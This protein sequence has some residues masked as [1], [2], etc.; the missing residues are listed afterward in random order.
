MASTNTVPEVTAEDLR[1]SLSRVDP[2]RKRTDVIMRVVVY[3]AFA[4]AMAPLISLVWSVLVRGVGRL[5]TYFLLNSMR[6]VFGGMDAGGAYHAIVG[7]LVITGWAAL[8]SVPIGLMVAIYLV[9][10]GTGRLAKAVTFLVDVMTGIPSIVAGLFAFALFYLLIGPQKA[11]IIGSVA[12]ALLMTP[13]VIRSSEEMLRLVPNELRE[14]SYALGVPKW[15]TTIKVVLR[16]AVAGLTTGVMLA[17]ARVIGETAPLIITVGMTNSIN[18]DVFRENM[19]TLPVYVWQQFGLG[20]V[21][22]REGATDCIATINFDRAWAA[23][24]TLILIVM[25]LNLVARGVSRW[26]APKVRG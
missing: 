14:A 22:C 17:I 11:G 23:A 20:L 15:L 3:I 13:V 26:F 10:Y 16:T 19:M 21:P 25:L 9:E 6:N 8:I 1:R 12:L 24:L 18:N 5:D 2:A 4:L 7:T